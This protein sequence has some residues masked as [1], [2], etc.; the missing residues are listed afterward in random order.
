M[1]SSKVV[2]SFTFGEVVK[3]SGVKAR[4]LDHW[5]TT[6]FLSPSVRKADG[7][8]TRRVYSFSDVLA[9]RVARELRSEGASLQGLRKVVRELRKREFP[10]SFA[11]NRLIVAGKDVYVKEDQDFISTLRNPGQLHFPFTVLD[12]GAVIVTLRNETKKIRAPAA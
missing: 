7:T 5:A 10:E 6:G 9:A 8:G 3:L 2:E 12:L 4:T 1:R 11:E